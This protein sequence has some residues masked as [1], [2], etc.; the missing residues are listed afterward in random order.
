M[1]EETYFTVLISISVLFVG[2]IL[3]ASSANLSLLALDTLTVEIVRPLP[4]TISAC[5]AQDIV[6]V[7]KGSAIAIAPKRKVLWLSDTTYYRGALDDTGSMGYSDV[8]DSIVAWGYGVEELHQGVP[9]DAVMLADYS[10]VVFGNVKYNP[11]SPGS[12]M[13]TAAEK[14]ALTDFVGNGGNVLS[15]SGWFYSRDDSDVENFLLENFGMYFN[16][17][18]TVSWFDSVPPEPGSPIEPGVNWVT[19]NGPKW[20]NGYT[21]CWAVSDTNCLCGATYYG[22]GKVV[23]HGDEHWLFNTPYAGSISF[24]SHQNARLLKNILDFFHP[25]DTVTCPIIPNSIV[26]NVQGADYMVS[27]PEL[28]WLRDTLRFSPSSDWDDGEVVRACLEMVVDSCF[29]TLPEPVCWEFQ[30][31]LSPPAL[32]D[33]YPPCGT[34][35][36]P[37]FNDEWTIILTDSPAGIMPDS[38]SVIFE[39]V[40]YPI[41]GPLPG[42]EHSFNFTWDPD[43]YGLS[44]VPGD[45]V[46][47]CVKTV[48]GPVQ[49][50]E[51]NDTVYC[52]DYPV[53][54][55]IGP[56]ASVVRVLDGDISACDPESIVLSIVSDYGVVESTIVLDVNGTEYIVD[57]VRLVWRDPNLVFFPSPG[58][59]AHDTVQVTLISAEDIFGNNCS[60][61]PL[62]WRFFIDRTPPTSELIQPYRA[63]ADDAHQQV[64]IAVHD[65]LAGVNPVSII[66]TINGVDYF[67]GDFDWIP[68]GDGLGGTIVWNPQDFSIEF[69]TGDSVEVQVRI[70]D[71]PDLCGPNF[72]TA[73]YSF[74]VELPT[75]CLVLPNP[76]TPN[77]DDVNDKVRFEFNGMLE[78]GGVVY[79]YSLDNE[80]IRELRNGDVEYFTKARSTEDLHRQYLER[81]DNSEVGVGL[82]YA[83]DEVFIMHILYLH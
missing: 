5:K 46:T 64:I 7:I 32:A 66:L 24:H 68:D 18:P 57:G 28:E 51:P 35:V 9:F 13:Y 74:V 33:L 60:N 62:S 34:D 67:P 54:D 52:C 2:A 4:N 26:L 50:C 1:G 16:D 77:G 8:R 25:S 11:S 47:L 61:T 72:H 63:F 23:G 81:H 69:S 3:G 36:V 75:A 53:V 14:A 41:T 37:G 56:V 12:R 15:T 6:L 78:K 17:S 40:E 22:S 58:W 31:D 59:S 49:Y 83:S 76:F 20:V 79:I 21:D 39:G 48:D 27:D 10:V 73:N 19:A 82:F 42:S 44:L 38:T 65:D 45:T 30:I 55:T 70:G 71:N 80:F 43:D 29:D